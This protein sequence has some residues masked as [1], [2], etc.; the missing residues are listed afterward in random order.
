ML[1]ITC[2][3]KNHNKRKEGAAI[4][5]NTALVMLYGYYTSFVMYLSVSVL[6]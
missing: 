5:K 4:I 2:I 3:I 6:P 1:P